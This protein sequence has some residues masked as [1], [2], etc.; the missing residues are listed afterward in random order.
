[1]KQMA[2][3]QIVPKQ[4][5]KVFIAVVFLA[6][7]GCVIPISGVENKMQVELDAFSGRPNPYWTLTSSEARDF[8][9]RFRSLPQYQGEGS[10]KEGLG[11]RGLIVTEPGQK[12]E[13]YNAIVV[14][15]GVVEARWDS[16]SR[17]FTDQNREL[18][19]WLFQTGRGR[20]DDELYRQVGQSAQLN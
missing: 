20:L 2:Q 4:V 10:V 11:Y 12:I 17:Q 5:M 15:N 7:L 8:A 18:E 13:S 14:S 3:L 9:I 16:Q 6:L 1:M 19:R